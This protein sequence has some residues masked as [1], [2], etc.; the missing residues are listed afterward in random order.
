MVASAQLVVSGDTGVAHLA[1]AYRTPS[2][3]LFGPVSPSLW[4]PRDRRRHAVIWHADDQEE[5]RPGDAAADHIDRRLA[6]IGP[7]EVVD[8]GCAL[9]EAFAGDPLRAADLPS[10]LPAPA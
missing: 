3:T 6:D 7:R 2:V 4:G 1:Y 8:A 5:G 10:R 9:L